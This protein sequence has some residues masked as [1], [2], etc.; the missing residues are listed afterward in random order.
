VSWAMSEL[1]NEVHTA[2]H[3]DAVRKHVKAYRNMGICVIPREFMSKG[4]GME[5]K[6]YQDTPPSD[7]DVDDWFYNSNNTMWNIAAV[8]GPVSGNLLAIDVD[9]DAGQM[10]MSKALSDLGWCNNLRVTLM[11]TMMTRS[12]SKRGYHFL[13]RVSQELLEDEQNGAFYRDLLLRPAQQPLWQGK[14]EHEEIKLLSKGSVAILAPSIHPSGRCNFYVWNGK[15]PQTIQSKKE[16]LELFSIFSED[17]PE[18]F[19]RNRRL[20]WKKRV[21]ALTAGRGGSSSTEEATKVLTEE[22]TENLT[23]VTLPEYKP[24]SR[25]DKVF[26][27]SGEL[28]KRGYSLDS[29][30]DFFT[31]LCRAANDEEEESRLET[32]RRTY[33]KNAAEVAGLGTLD[34]F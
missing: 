28:Y 17:S 5:W 16:L 22:Q 11:N 14:G 29:A 31:R 34:D 13:F 26:R 3:I 8:L 4:N 32:I 7:K 2:S 12:G 23:K 10:R 1:F 21:Q 33:R 27:L 19:W 18:K 15:A 30:I 20:R 25:D 6:Q 9:G 24:G